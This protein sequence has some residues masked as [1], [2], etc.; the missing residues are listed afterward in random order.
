MRAG[1][2]CLKENIFLLIC[3]LSIIYI[4]LCIQWRKSLAVTIYLCVLALIK[5]TSDSA[6]IISEKEFSSLKFDKI[7]HI[8]QIFL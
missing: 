1:L 8:E 7:N 5:S 6:P 4:R 2:S 3:V